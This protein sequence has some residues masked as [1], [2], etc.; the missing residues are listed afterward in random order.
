MNL[1]K[2]NLL[3][4]IVLGLSLTFRI[5][6]QTSIPFRLPDTGQVISYTDTPGEDAD[7]MINPMSFT[8]H[9]NGTITDN[10][11][12]LM[13][14]KTDG[15]EMTIEKAVEYCKT[16]SLG[17]YNDW[18]LPSSHELFNISQYDTNP[19]LNP[20]YF[21]N[22][23]AGYW[24]TSDYR[25]DDSSRVWVVNSGGGIGPHPKSETISAGGSKRFHVRAVRNIN[26]PKLPKDHFIDNKNGTITDNYTGLVWQQLQS[27]EVMTW[28][29]ALRFA[30]NLSLTGKKDWR[31][32]NI[33]ELQSLNDE[34]LFRP[35][36]NKNYF[37]N[38][39][40]GNFWSSTT[41]KQPRPDKGWTINVDF[42]I[43]SYNAKT[44][45]QN[46]LCVRGG[47]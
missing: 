28:E 10:V 9:G 37:T 40:S 21:P 1:L 42:G 29:D 25:A 4:V 11:T 32:P 14:Q 15:G 7:I 44:T 20:E 47:L 33:K 22:T 26:T 16:L 34:K 17:G 2:A 8:D 31:L 27:P 3:I 46:V 18:R 30:A 35:S 45:L 5:S 23:G 41:L 19:A 12:R 39:S 38:I 36:F 24:W 13:W 43:V 6:A